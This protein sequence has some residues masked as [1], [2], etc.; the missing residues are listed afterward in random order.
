MSAS[1][2]LRRVENLPW[3]LVAGTFAILLVLVGASIANYATVADAHARVALSFTSAA[4]FRGAAAD[5]LLPDN[6]TLAFTVYFHVD[7]PTSRSLTFFTLGYRV[8][9]EDGPAEAHLSV[10]RSP[11]DVAVTNSTGSHTFFRALDGSLQTPP[12]PIPAGTNTTVPVTLYLSRANDSARFKAIQNITE[13]AVNVLGG[14][15]RIVWNVWVLV[16]LDIGGI[17]APASF[18]EAPYFATISRI[19]F[20]EGIDFGLV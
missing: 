19:Q 6:G 4:V 5:G 11:A 18:S 13:Y 7:D 10:S 2:G 17:P 20:T 16:N 3:L 15:S 1:G 9:A 12:Y 14:T 8:W